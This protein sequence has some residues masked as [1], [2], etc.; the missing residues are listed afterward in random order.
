V[1]LAQTEKIG[2][3]SVLWQAAL[4]TTAKDTV[5]NYFHQLS[6]AELA[7]NEEPFTFAPKWTPIKRLHFIRDNMPEEAHS[8][9][10]WLHILPEHLKIQASNMRKRC[11]LLFAAQQSI[12]N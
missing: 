1:V 4:D 12:G 6:T 2:K 7:I 11:K 3:W 5:V 8:S 9:N 10:V